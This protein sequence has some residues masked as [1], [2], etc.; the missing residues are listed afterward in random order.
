MIRDSYVRDI[1]LIAG[2][3]IDLYSR[4]LGTPICTLLQIR[5]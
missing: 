1:G 4:N 5:A 3:V 2:L